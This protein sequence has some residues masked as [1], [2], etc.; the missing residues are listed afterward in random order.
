MASI[1]DISDAVRQVLSYGAARTAIQLNSATRER[2]F[3]AYVFSL[4]VRAVRQAGGVVTIK[5]INS[6]NNPDPIIFRGGPGHMSSRSQNFAYAECELNSRSFEVHVDVQYV[7][8]SGAVHE[9]DVSI[10]DHNRAEIVRES[11]IIPNTR[12]LRAALE[13]KFYMTVLWGSRL[14]ERLSVYLAI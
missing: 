10:F 4:V 3:E 7:G 13:C 2:A 11:N 5:G 12:N 9:V 14:V 8:T 1:E 6:G